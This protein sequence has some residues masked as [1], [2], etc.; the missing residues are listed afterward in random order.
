MKREE[1]RTLGE[2]YR[3]IGVVG[4]VT[5]VMWLVTGAGWLWMSPFT[6][7]R[8]ETRGTGDSGDR[9]AFIFPA[10]T[11]LPVVAVCYSLAFLNVL[12]Q[13]SIGRRDHGAARTRAMQVSGGTAFFATVALVCMMI[14][15]G[16]VEDLLFWF[17][18]IL[19]LVAGLVAALALFAAR[20]ADTERAAALNGSTP[21][22][23]S[24]GP[25]VQR[26]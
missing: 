7:S 16:E 4:T 21:S 8:A 11:G 17:P 3:R 20:T 23:E 18:P 2:S 5:G 14:R 22:D 13:W 26:T 19:A 24:G 10:E 1:L 6:F 9:G 15:A 25:S 12:M